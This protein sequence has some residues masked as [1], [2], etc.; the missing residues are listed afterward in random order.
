METQRYIDYLRSKY[1]VSLNGIRVV[2]S[3]IRPG[4]PGT[5]WHDSNV[6]TIYNG[7]LNAIPL[8][9][10]VL[11]IAFPHLLHIIVA[12]GAYLAA[13]SLLNHLSGGAAV[14]HEIMHAAIRERLGKVGKDNL[15]DEGLAE[16]LCEHEASSAPVLPRHVRVANKLLHY[17]APMVYIIRSERR[18]LCYQHLLRLVEETGSSGKVPRS[19]DSAR[20]RLQRSKLSGSQREL[21]FSLLEDEL[22]GEGDDPSIP[23]ALIPENLSRLKA[24]KVSFRLAFV[25]GLRELLR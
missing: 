25:G 1:S 15:G 20:D 23:L 19:L 5:Y 6:I 11:A 16:A 10:L 21:V 4:F 9:V 7:Y 12:A 2:V 17:L 22:K 8:A 3:S 13:Y 18:R 24:I 14:V